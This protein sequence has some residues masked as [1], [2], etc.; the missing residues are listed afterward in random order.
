V[1]VTETSFSDSKST[2]DDR[3]D[4]GSDLE[5]NE[6]EICERVMPLTRHHLIPKTTHKKYIDRP[7]HV[8]I[9]F[10]STGRLSAA[11]TRSV[12]ATLFVRHKPDYHQGDDKVHSK[13]VEQKESEGQDECTVM[14][15]KEF[16]NR[17]V[18]HI[19]R[20]CHSAIHSFIDQ[21]TMAKDFH[22]LDLLLQNEKVKKFI[23]FIRKQQ[24]RTK[25][26]ALNPAIRYKK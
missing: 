3:E 2:P 1:E 5:D 15:S 17:Y 4:S 12:S 19:C 21:E 9:H 24:T 14:Y 11:L 26:D 20:P 8:L 6:C 16:L 18:M 13:Q 10:H 25:R 22:S 23:P 7:N